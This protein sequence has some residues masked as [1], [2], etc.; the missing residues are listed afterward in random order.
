MFKVVILGNSDMLANLIM[1]TIDA[2]CKIVGVFRYEK[3]KN[4]V[5]YQKFKD[6]LF[7]SKEYSFIKSHKLPEIKAKKANSE[8][9]K[10]ELLKLNPDIVLVGTW[11]E[12]LRKDILQLPKIAMIN[13]HPSLLPKYRGPN[14]YLRTI[15]NGEQKSGITFHLMDEN[16]DT[17]AILMQKSVEI[18][19]DDTG[20]ELRERTILAVRESVKE[21]LCQLDEDFII[22]VNQSETQ[23]SYYPQISQE[24]VMLDFT[25]SAQE[26]Y[27]HIKAF[28]PW[29]K[30][31][32]SHKEIFLCPNPYFVQILENDTEDKTVGIIVDKDVQTRS[33]TVVCGDGKLLKMS[34][35]RLYGCILKFFTKSY[36]KYMVKKSDLI[37]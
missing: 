5:I 29:C 32:F 1:G 36:I 25:K 11:S 31:Y 33:I 21:L 17:G 9:F 22:P 18:K 35:L 23:A 30:T 28:F 34:N 16:F 13:V 3:M 26:N 20:K 12:K 4:G 14:P 2:K 27:N 8:Q 6:F 24:D 15:W 10:K 19:L 37:L 7:P